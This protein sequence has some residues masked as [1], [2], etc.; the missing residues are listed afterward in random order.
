MSD[1]TG[2]PFS[3]PRGPP[4]APDETVRVLLSVSRSL[5][6]VFA[7]L[8]GVLFLLLL[9]L[10]V[11]SAVVGRGLGEVVAAVYCLA[12][13]AVNFTIWKQLPRLEGLAA[14]RRYA[15]LREPLLLWGVLGLVFF[16]IV[17][18]FLLVAWLKAELLV[19]PRTA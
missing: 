10:G 11:L 18:A 2:S 5:A 12:S 3:A 17:G 9:V 15:A 14:E 16:V 6:L 19:N 8:A 1:P 7:L 13:A 4:N